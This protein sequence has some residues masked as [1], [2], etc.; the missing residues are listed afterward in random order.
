MLDDLGGGAVW[1]SLQCLAGGALELSHRCLDIL[2]GAGRLRCDRDL[3]AGLG[4][5]RLLLSSLLSVFAHGQVSS[6]VSGGFEIVIAQR[7]L[8]I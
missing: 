7:A 5:T 8:V 6:E 1:R 2:A 4:H 3:V